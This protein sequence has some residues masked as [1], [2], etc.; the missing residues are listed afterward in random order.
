LISTIKQIAIN[1]EPLD[2]TEYTAVKNKFISSPNL[3]D[4]FK[5]LSIETWKRIEYAY[6]KP[7]I[8]VFETTLTQNLIFTI[9]AYND[10][11]GLNIEVLE[12]VDEN[13]NGNDLELVIRYPAYGTE[14]YA[15]IQAKKIYRTGRYHSM[16]HGAQINSLRKYATNKVAIPLYLLYNFSSATNDRK[17]GVPSPPELLGCTII[18]ADHLHTNYYNKRTVLHRDGT[19]GL[20]WKIPRYE[21]LVPT[22]S[23]CWHEL[24]C[25][26]S[27]LDLFKR[28]QQKQLV[29]HSSIDNVADLL[30]ANSNY[31]LGFH[32][33][34]T[35]RTD[36]S[37]IN[38]KELSVPSLEGWIVERPLIYKAD[39]FDELN[40]KKLKRTERERSYPNF[41]P[42][43]RIILTK[44]E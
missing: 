34:N 6:L 16:D 30:W 22:P 5:L 33:I 24:V 35:F 23:F 36:E 38:I 13:T 14:F 20:A 1:Y 18:G 17:T 39:G 11:Y 42:K 26:H 7:G 28:F 41:S 29:F 21:D 25:P 43:S 31:Q 3:C 4:L 9:N 44:Q 19:S 10:Q 40:E 27:P 15:P 12:A 2:Y 8:K 32:E 37:W